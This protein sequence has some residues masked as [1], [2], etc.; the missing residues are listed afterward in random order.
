MS[1]INRTED[2]ADTTSNA[3]DVKNAANAANAE[4]AGNAGKASKESLD[5]AKKNIG[6]MHEQIQNCIVF[7]VELSEDVLGMC[8]DI[9]RAVKDNDEILEKVIQ[10]LLT[11]PN[12][13]DISGD[14]FN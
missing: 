8:L 11:T 4:H 10:Y 13:N 1:K 7:N 14:L 3:G 12:F 6:I 5:S 9:L 2:V